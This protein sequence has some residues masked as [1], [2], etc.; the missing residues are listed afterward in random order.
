MEIEKKEIS[1]NIIL[2]LIELSNGGLTSSEFDQIINQLN[3][4]FAK[5]NYSSTAENNFLRIISSLY[6]KINFLRSSI[7]HNHY[8]EYI[9]LI[10]ANSNYLTDIIVRNPEYLYLLFNSEFLNNNIDL[11]TLNKEIDERICNYKSFE[12]K[13]NFLR[14][15]KRKYLLEIG[16]N[17]ILGNSNIYNTTSSLS[18]LAISI[19]RCLFELCFNVIKQKYNFKHISRLYSLASLGKLGGNELNYSS[20]IDLVLFYDRNLP[21]C[22]FSKITANDFFNEVIFLFIKTATAITEKGY[23][24]RVDF[25]LRPEGRN[26]SLSKSIN[27]YIQYYDTRGEDWE[28]QM[29]L[30]LN[31]VCGDKSLYNKFLNFTQSYIFAKSIFISPLYQIKSMK[32]RI[33]VGNENDIKLCIGGIRDIE[34]SIQALQLINGGRHKQLYDGNSISV[35]GKLLNLNIINLDEYTLLL[36]AYNF[37]RKVE[38]YLQLMN[39]RQTHTIPNNVLMLK[40]MALYL[41]LSSESVFY[42]VL[43]DHKNNVRKFFLTVFEES[44]ETNNSGTSTF[45]NIKFKD[46]SRANKNINF[47]RFGTD[48][49]ESKGFDSKT[50]DLFKEIEESINKY[51][52]NSSVPDLVLENFVRGIKS[53][54]FPSLWYSGFRD[55]EFLSRFLILCEFSSRLFNMWLLNKKLGDLLLTGRVFVKEYVHQ[56]LNL[57]INELLFILSA[58]YTLKIISAV[59]LSE[60]L[61]LLIKFKINNIYSSLNINSFSVFAL[62]SFGISAMNFSSDIDLIFISETDQNTLTVNQTAE[63]FIAVLTKELAPFKL[64]FRLRPEGQNSQIVWDINSFSQYLNKRARIWELQT[65]QK[66]KFVSGNKELFNTVVIKFLAHLKTINF[67]FINK[68][69]FEMY[70]TLIN[71]NKSILDNLKF[72][73]GSIIDIDFY[74]QLSFFYFPIVQNQI[75]EI[76]FFKRFNYFINYISSDDLNILMNNYYFLK[77][78]EI[79]I[80][81]IFGVNN[82]NVPIDTEK[83][84]LLIKFLNIN[85]ID[86]FKSIYIQTLI[87]NQKILSKYQEMKNETVN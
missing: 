31:Y 42:T 37:Y 33:E 64:D 80:Q 43:N 55:E 1:P 45:E 9:I 66:I 27:D 65:L 29:L 76:T 57:G 39:D 71:N 18:K 7:K 14:L 38:H 22:R 6:D 54:Y 67:E 12:S 26:S 86:E 75:I 47:L 63:K 10:S 59:E 21:V 40:S 30:K 60:L 46:K 5:V 20:D 2:K 11:K 52:S 77:T 84:L 72:T 16:L 15:F 79:T 44:A 24:Y 70:K 49:F 87:S 23:I 4:I 68:N 13:V 51:L 25:R 41:N 53:V 73:K 56:N 35:M 3:D 74:L 50:I 83:L 81:N 82:S 32:K 85:S 34:F 19:S 58:Q 61:T 48:L 69:V 36:D 78:L 28:R 62:G 8:F 17:D